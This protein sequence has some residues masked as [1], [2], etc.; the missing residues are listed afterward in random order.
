MPGKTKAPPTDGITL[1]V[2][3]TYLIY[4][5]GFYGLYEPKEHILA[6]TSEKGYK[7]VSLSTGKAT[8]INTC[9]SRTGKK[10][11]RNKIYKL[12]PAGVPEEKCIMIN[13]PVWLSGRLGNVV[14]QGDTNATE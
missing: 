2:G 7:F 12:I 3:S 5:R 6:Q 8:P 14:E 4:K 10:Y 13:V 11:W 1:K 9:L